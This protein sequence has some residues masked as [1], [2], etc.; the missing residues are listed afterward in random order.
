LPARAGMGTGFTSTSQPWIGLWARYVS[1]W[2]PSAPPDRRDII[3]ESYG[4]VAITIT[5]KQRAGVG[6]AVQGKVCKPVCAMYEDETDDLGLDYI[7][8]QAL[9]E[10]LEAVGI[11]LQFEDSREETGAAHT[12]TI[13]NKESVELVKRQADNLAEGISEDRPISAVVDGLLATNIEFLGVKVKA[14]QK[15]AKAPRSFGAPPDCNPTGGI[16]AHRSRL[17]TYKS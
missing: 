9:T 6:A 14:P 11:A 1:Y 16:G 13:S 2:S 17:L 3:M 12:I 5:A 8:G 10:A 7:F 4:K 15:T